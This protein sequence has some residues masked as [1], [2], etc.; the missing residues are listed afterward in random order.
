MEKLLK[1][2]IQAET[3]PEKG[4]LAAAE[5][6]AVELDRSGV[7]YRIDNWDANRANI[8]AHIKSTGKK[9]ALLFVCHLDVVGAGEES[10]GKPPFGAVERDGK[11]YGRGGADMKGGNSTILSALC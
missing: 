1:K 7:D 5:I 2:L 8:T 10:W 9:G 11:I 4:E 3:T 6:I